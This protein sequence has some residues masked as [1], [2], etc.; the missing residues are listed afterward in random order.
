MTS[1]RGFTM[2]ELLVALAVV[3]VIGAGVAAVVPASR[4]VF[5]QTPAALDAQHRGRAAAEALAQPLR[6]AGVPGFVPPALALSP[7]PDGHGFQAVLAIVRR[8]NAAHGTLAADQAGGSG[9]L[10]LADASCPDVD[11]VCGFTAG[12]TAVIADGA[13]RFD[14]FM[15]SE[16]NE[17]AHRLRSA[18]AFSAPYAADAIVVEVD[19]H[20]YRLDAQPDG[21]TTLVRE[22]MAGV[23]QPIVDRVRALAF[24]IVD[25]R[26]EVSFIVDPVPGAVGAYAPVP[27]AYTFAV[28]LRNAS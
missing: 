12:A 16:V 4:V 3:S 24:S 26:V 1:D 22:T 20:T 11:E 28:H 17:G 14:L 6:T 8:A 23:T 18:R 19:A 2:V 15:V 7:H 25:A 5:E 10:V 9:A 21:S 13:G 27:R